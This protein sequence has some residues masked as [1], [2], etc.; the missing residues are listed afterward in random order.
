MLAVVG[1]LYWGGGSSRMGQGRGGNFPLINGNFWPRLGGGG[2]K[3]Y[4]LD[5]EGGSTAAQIYI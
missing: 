3:V 2:L 5:Y 1:V 4:L